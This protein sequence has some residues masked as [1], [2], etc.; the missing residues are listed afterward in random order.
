MASRGP[1]SA[2]RRGTGPGG[3]DQGC[4]R[5]RGDTYPRAQFCRACGCFYGPRQRSPT[6]HGLCTNEECHRSAAAKARHWHRCYTPNS[7][8][9]P[10]QAAGQEAPP[11]ANRAGQG[12]SRDAAIGL[13][14]LGPEPAPLLG[15]PAEASADGRPR[16]R[17]WADPAG[18]I[19][20]ETAPMGPSDVPQTPPPSLPA[21]AEASASSRRWRGQ[22]CGVCG[23]FYVHRDVSR[24]RRGFGTNVLCIRSAAAKEARR[25]RLTE[26]SWSG[27]A[28]S[29]WHQSQW[30][31]ANEPKPEG[32]AA[33]GVT[34][35]VSAGQGPSRD[36]PVGRPLVPEPTLLLG[37]PAGASADGPLQ[38]RRWADPA[39]DRDGDGADG[40]LRRSADAATLAAIV[41]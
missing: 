34:G 1:A 29:M 26:N 25:S 23:C 9:M 15:L 6:G 38:R 32:K 8:V 4:A 24:T 21:A 12:P 35:T 36:V 37:I 7:G 13:L 19:T 11:G 2:A 17:R 10:G 3:S 5:A 14:W 31:D 40:P 33:T 28:R 18:P 39:A 41:G 20:M 16:R 22:S 27:S 30:P